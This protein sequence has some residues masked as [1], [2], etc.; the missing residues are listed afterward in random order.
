MGRVGRL[1]G[2]GWGGATPTMVL[3]MADIADVTEGGRAGGAGGTSGAGGAG[4]LGAA[5]AGGAS[6]TPTMVAFIPRGG[7]GGATPGGPP[8]D[9]AGFV[10]KNECPHFGHRIFRPAGGTRRSSI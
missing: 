5:G 8:G 2:D 10:T 1:C 6:P 9:A 3:F 4:G 7:P